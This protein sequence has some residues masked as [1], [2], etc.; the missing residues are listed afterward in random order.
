MARA[1]GSNFKM[2]VAFESVYGTAPASGYR[3]MPLA[4]HSLG[5]AQP[6]LDNELLG[7][8]RD[9]LAPIKDAVTVDGQL[10]VPIDVENIGVWLKA[11]LGAPVTTGTSPYVHTFES[12]AASLPSLAIE[13][14]HAD[15]P[16][17][18][19]NTGVK[20]DRLRW[21]MERS[22]QLRMDLDLVAQGQETDTVSN[23]GTPTAYSLQRF[24]NFNGS[25]LRDGV[26]LGNIVSAQW[27]YANNLDRIETIRAD[28]K[29]DGLDAGMA[30]LS[31]QIVSRFANT[32]L[33]DQAIAGASCELECSY[34]IG[35]SA[36][37]LFTAPAV[38][39]PRFKTPVEG[40]NGVQVT[41][42]W[43]AAQGGTPSEMLQVVL[44]NT[45]A[46]Y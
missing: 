12:G 37:L 15:V 32:T 45:V 36:S 30:M 40:P 8:G 2:N 17:Y 27:T 42:D 21:T 14:A 4:S 19:M 35:A 43:Q 20:V 9:P 3:T 38:Y 24:G 23:A 22:G 26:A 5:A 11:A 41:I 28:G 25:I 13:M 44:T 33:L 39:L 16:H 46:T 29:I 31:G 10:A 18:E 6:L 34:V 1:R 7:F